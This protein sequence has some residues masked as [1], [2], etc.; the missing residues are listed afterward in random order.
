[1]MECEIEKNEKGII[2][3]RKLSRKGGA[4]PAPDKIGG[5]P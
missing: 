2:L 5:G 3:P 4:N 1:M